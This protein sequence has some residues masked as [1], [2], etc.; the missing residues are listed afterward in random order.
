MAYREGLG[1]LLARVSSGLLNESGG[2]GEVCHSGEREEYPLD[3]WGDKIR[4][5]TQAAADHL[6]SSQNFQ[7]P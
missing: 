1:D 5:A 3:A 4:F 7:R 2:S 6:Y